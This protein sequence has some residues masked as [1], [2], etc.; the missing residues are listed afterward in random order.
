MNFG[1]FSIL[2][3]HPYYISKLYETQFY[4]VSM[5]IM[6]NTLVIPLLSIYLLKK[7]KFIDDIYIRD[8]KQRLIPYSI[9]IALLCFTIYQLYKIDMHGLPLVFMAAS[10]FC[11]LCNVFINLKFTISTHAIGAGGLSA[12]YFYLTVFEHVSAYNIL[13]IISVLVAGISSWARL[14]L[15]AHS[16][17]QVYMGICLGFFVVL[18]FS[19]AMA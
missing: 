2:R 8:P 18:G 12:L 13:L 7:F 15:N 5:F 17:K 10:A 1:L 19:I 6:V 9:L 16:E 11:L 14:L 4:T 3:F